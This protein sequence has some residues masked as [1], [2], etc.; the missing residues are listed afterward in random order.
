LDGTRASRFVALS[1][2][3]T[4]REYPNKPSNI[5]DGDQTV[6]PP[7]ELT[8]A[9]FGCFDWH[10]AVHGHWA[11]VRI[12][13]LFPDLPETDAIRR[14][15]DLHLRPE[16]IARELEYFKLEHN[17]TFERPYGWGWLMRLAAELHALDS[18]H[19]RRWYRALEPL[20]DLLAKHTIDYLRRLTL[21]IRAGTHANTAFALSHAL[22]YARQ[23][24]R[25]P[26]R[27]AIVQAAIRFY[28]RDRN[29]PTD[30]EPSG[31]DFIS[32]CLAEADLMRRI[33]E[34]HRFAR[35]LDDFLPGAD[36]Q[37]FKPLLN[38]PEIKDLRDPR[39][40]HLIGLGFHRAW[41]LTGVASGLPGADPRQALYR[42]LANLHCAE[43][44][45]RMFNSG[46]GGA[47]WLASFAIYHLADS[48]GEP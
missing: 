10:S 24:R 2:H 20:A 41:T 16:L 26:L 43:A 21:P 18:P 40:G 36:S 4:E 11:M 14:I 6:R 37:E 42:R 30:Y 38:P 28:G 12:L 39:I 1:I 27:R 32:P 3:C 29:C 13:R 44:A 23:T 15:L 9:F 19:A 22:D 34:P 33:H 47:H 17:R 35:W 48:G 25:E 46:Y 31:E 8:P 5:V 45:D 7:R